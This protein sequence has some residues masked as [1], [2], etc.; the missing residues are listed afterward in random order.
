MLIRNVGGAASGEA[1][2]ASA[3]CILTPM[4]A[5]TTPRVSL[6]YFLTQACSF[7]QS[8]LRYEELG[9]TICL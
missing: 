4:F 3:R 5:D 9:F 7:S 1:R 8:L 6:Q 2:H